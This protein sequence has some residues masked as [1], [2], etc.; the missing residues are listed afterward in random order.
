[1]QAFEQPQPSVSAVDRALLQVL[2]KLAIDGRAV[3]EK[4]QVVKKSEEA[5]ETKSSDN[6]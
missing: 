5:I 3:R 4:A 6:K 1:L 2:A